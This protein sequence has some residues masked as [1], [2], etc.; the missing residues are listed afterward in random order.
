M[1]D[2]LCQTAISKNI[3]ATEQEIAEWYNS[4]DLTSIEEQIKQ[5]IKVEYWDGESPVNGVPA[6]V[7]KSS[8]DF[9][10]NTSAKGYFIYIDGNLTLFQY[11]TLSGKEAITD[12]NIGEES[13]KHVQQ[14]VKQFMQEEVVNRFLREF[15]NRT[16][17][18]ILTQ[19]NLDLM[20]ALAD[21]A[22][23]LGVV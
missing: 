23:K 20:T 2:V 12:S 16:Q 15:S 7:I 9:P 4:L 5:R 11:H 1:I 21:I 19:Q 22:V 14:L 3:A 10:Q 18:N 8:P 13:T 17:A 6:S